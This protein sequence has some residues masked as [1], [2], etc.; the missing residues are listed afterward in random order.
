[1]PGSPLRRRRT[2][3]APTEDWTQLQL[4][5]QFREQL[6]YELIRPIVLFGRSPAE[7]AQQTGKPE[8]TI[9]RKADRFDRFGMASL[10]GATRFGL[11]ERATPRPSLPP[12]IRQA[13]VDLREEYHDFT[14]REIAT[15][16]YVRFGRR[17]S[18]HTIKRVL[19]VGPAP[20][21]R[22]KAARRYA[23]YAQIPDPADARLAVIRLHADIRTMEAIGAIDIRTMEA[24]GA[25]DS[26][27]CEMYYGFWRDP[28]GVALLQHEIADPSACRGKTPNPSLGDV[29]G[30]LMSM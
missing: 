13:I 9:R 28:A 17:P 19:A 26:S 8:R 7:R 22:G 23:P 29:V 30:P 16:C 27:P 5:F 24:I 20:T 25:I 21:R 11:T 2:R 3:I 4:Q 6:A 18:P 1:M 12:P 15:I 10:F 14:F